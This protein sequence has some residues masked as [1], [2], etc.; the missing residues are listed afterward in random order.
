MAMGNREMESAIVDRRSGGLLKA[1]HGFFVTPGHREIAIQ[2]FV[3]GLGLLLFGSWVDGA[4]MRAGHADGFRWIS[5]GFEAGF[6]HVLGYCLGLFGVV[7]GGFGNLLVPL[8]I[9]ANDRYGVRLGRLGLWL[10]MASLVCVAAIV[11]GDGYWMNRE[12]LTLHFLAGLG[13][14]ASVVIICVEFLVLGRRSRCKGMELGRVPMAART[15]IQMSV[16]LILGLVII[17]LVMP[18][19]SYEMYSISEDGWRVWYL[20]DSGG[21]FWRS[22]GDVIRGLTAFAVFGMLFDVAAGLARNPLKSRM[23]GAVACVVGGLALVGS[24]TIGYVD[25]SV[26]DG[27]GT[28]CDMLAWIA[29]AVLSIVVFASAIPREFRFLPGL[30]FTLFAPIAF[31]LTVASRSGNGIEGMIFPALFASI[32]YWYPR[33]FRRNLNQALGRLHFWMTAV[34]ILFLLIPPVIFSSN[35]EELRDLA[36]A[37]LW[38]AQ[39]PFVINIVASMFKYGNRI[40]IYGGIF[41]VFE[42][43]CGRLAFTDYG[44]MGWIWKGMTIHWA[45]RLLLTLGVVGVMGVMDWGLMRAFPTKRKHPRPNRW[46]GVAVLMTALPIFVSPI[47][48]S[49]VLF[50]WPSW[51][52]WLVIAASAVVGLLSAFRRGNRLTFGDAVSDNPWR[53]NSLEWYERPAEAVAAGV[54][55]YPEDVVVYRGAYV[56]GKAED[57]EDHRPQWV[58]AS[59]LGRSGA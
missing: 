17:N 50:E 54:A 28:I 51:L 18:Y 48:F 7:F 56:Y 14:M 10:F 55:S 4:C 47:V 45:L 39:I 5:C 19:L 34:S 20:L 2:F 37:M 9:G 30:Y 40:F 25:S 26:I 15:M 16:L 35:L 42:V 49:N 53:A 33:M 43:V 41:L 23:V 44:V 58:G 8:Q 36:M 29:L 1:G 38:A 3:V 13:F 22:L 57:E 21:Y 27:V 32:Y 24:A 46:V 31:F 12:N 52:A 59:E 11:R 6:S